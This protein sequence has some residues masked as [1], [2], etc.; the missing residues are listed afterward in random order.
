[1][2]M[3][4]KQC[5]RCKQKDQT[6]FSTC[7][8]CGTNYSFV[9]PKPKKSKWKMEEIIISLVL[10]FITVT[11]LPRIID[12]VGYVATAGQQPYMYRYLWQESMIRIFVNLSNKY[13]TDQSEDHWRRMADDPHPE[14][15]IKLEDV[16]FVAA[17]DH[18]SESEA[19]AKIQA[20][21]ELTAS[22][23]LRR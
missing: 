4:V 16:K 13:K 18:L 11:N 6:D 9:L 10:A 17:R 12:S 8:F 20:N 7:R 15:P 19:R 21:R 14:K 2:A 3:A 23:K 22:E 5:V 1:M